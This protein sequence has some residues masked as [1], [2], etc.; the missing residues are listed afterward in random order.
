V[1]RASADVFTP[2]ACAASGGRA[3]RD[4]APRRDDGGT[5]RAVR[6][7]IR[8]LRR[9]DFLP[10]D[11]TIARTR[12]SVKDAREGRFGRRGSRATCSAS[13]SRAPVRP[14]A[15]GARRPPRDCAASPTRFLSGADGWMSDGEDAL[16]Q[17]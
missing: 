11:A 9:I 16:G 4:R 5:S 13:G 3:A 1:R 7:R 2:A 6:E 12:I 14:R 8:A 15:R 17:V 10:A